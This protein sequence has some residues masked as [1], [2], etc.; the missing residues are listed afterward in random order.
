M[1]KLSSDDLRLSPLGKDKQGNC[2]WYQVDQG[3][4]LR[5]I[6]SSFH[7]LFILLSLILSSFNHSSFHHWSFHPLQNYNVFILSSFHSL[8]I[9]PFIIDLSIVLSFIHSSYHPFILL[10]VIHLFE[11]KLISNYKTFQKHYF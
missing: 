6:H 1:N 7:P 9:H 11:L 8:F 4:N 10:D 5:Y 2:Y 3:A